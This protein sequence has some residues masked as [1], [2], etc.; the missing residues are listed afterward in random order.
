[1]KGERLGPYRID[2][3]IGAGGMGTVFA[4]TTTEPVDGLALGAS[5][6]VKVVHPHLLESPDAAA[7]VE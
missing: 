3:E 7:P 6:A 1:M 5:V 2:R 4:A